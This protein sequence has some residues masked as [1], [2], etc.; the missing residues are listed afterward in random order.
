MPASQCKHVQHEAGVVRRVRVVHPDRLSVLPSHL[1]GEHPGFT[2][3]G[4]PSSPNVKG[5]TLEH[6]A[7]V[8]TLGGPVDL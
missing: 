7:G 4:N 8:A 2:E 3:G 1:S 6:P 5:G